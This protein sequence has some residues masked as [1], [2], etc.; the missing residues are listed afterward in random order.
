MFFAPAS[1]PDPD[2][3]FWVEFVIVAVI[4]VVA[5]VVLNWRRKPEA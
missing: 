4:T 2:T 5:G 3:G 1:W